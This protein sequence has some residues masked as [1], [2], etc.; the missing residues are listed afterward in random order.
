M[1]DFFGKNDKNST[2]NLYLKCFFLFHAA[3]GKPCFCDISVG[4]F[5]SCFFFVVVVLYCFKRNIA[6]VD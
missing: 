2:E 6:I 1:F 3:V 4:F 5:F